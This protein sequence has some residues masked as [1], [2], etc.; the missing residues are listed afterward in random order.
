MRALRE[1]EKSTETQES[2][3]G[4]DRE[5]EVGV[6]TMMCSAVGVYSSKPQDPLLLNPGIIVCYVCVG[7]M[8]DMFNSQRK[9]DSFQ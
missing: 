5:E 4:S 1:N 2:V 8:L 3:G 6:W 9:T 7:W